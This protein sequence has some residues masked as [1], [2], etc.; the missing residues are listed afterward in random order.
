MNTDYRFPDGFVWGSAT[1]SYQIEGAWQ[2]DGRGESTWDRFCRRP[3]KVINGDTGN[4]ACDHYHRYK[5]DIAL[6]KDLGLKN[7][8]L[9]VAWPRILPG[10]DGTVNRKGLDFYGRLV[11]EL[12]KA[13]IEPLITLFHW[14]LPQA[15]QDRF[16]GWKDRRCAE[17]FADYCDVVTRSLGDRV[18]KW[19][20]INEIMCFT[21]LAHQ[22]DV[23]A[24]GGM[25][26]TKVT[27]QT[28]HNALLG[29]G[30]ATRVVRGNVKDSFVGL[31]ENDIAAWPVMETPADIDAARRAWKDMNSQRLFPIFTGKYDEEG[32]R[33]QYGELPDYS[34][35]DMKIISEPT[36]Y[37]GINYYFGPAIQAADNEAGYEEVKLPDAFPRT[38][39]GW[40]S[41]PDGLYWNLKFLKE[42]FPQVPVYITENGM[43]ANDSMSEDGTVRDYD[44]IEFI[45]T[46]LR[47]C[48]RAMEEGANLKGY[49][50]W[51]LM[52]NFEWALGYSRRFGMIRVEYD[53]QKRIVK[54]SGKYY[55]RVMAENRLL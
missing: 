9:S 43:A 20:T 23:H 28:V 11:D 17:L 46:H 1:A 55:S 38:A 50:L 8:R 24:P 47:A 30:L 35:E 12:L 19:A 15:L 3:G 45:R 2:E 33:R 29:H 27:N 54:E 26:S 13:D 41:T 52:D 39:M 32:Y 25:E 51:S 31:V 40:A 5:E 37:I 4:V 42:F 22:E 36:D 16:G 10:G 14:D 18:R 34:D 53:T 7:Y 44:R 21:L 6:M 48:H 49:Y